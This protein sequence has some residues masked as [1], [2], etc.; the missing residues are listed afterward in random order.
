MSSNPPAPPP[1][2]PVNPKLVVLTFIGP[3]ERP[4]TVRL[5]NACSAAVNNGATDLTILFASHGGLI[6]EGFALYGFLR[7]LP[8]K[9]T[10]HAIGAVE[11]IASIIFLAAD[12]RFGTEQSHFMFHPFTWTFMQQ[13][14]EPRG[15]TEVQDNLENSKGKYSS[16]LESRTALTNKDLKALKLFEQ[17]VIFSPGVAKEKGIIKEVKQAAI[18]AGWTAWNI[19]FT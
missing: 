17:V 11:S 18:P 10:M 8:L 3:I 6:D 9:L 1:P 4:A 14:Y 16:I 13:K 5:R 7:A 12:Q 15:I 19:D 2:T